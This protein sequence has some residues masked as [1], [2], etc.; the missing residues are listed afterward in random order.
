MQATEAHSNW[1]L[2]L[3]VGFHL[4]VLMRIYFFGFDGIHPLHD[5]AT[6]SIEP[7]ATRL[8]A[9]PIPR[10]PGRHA[11]SSGATSSP[12]QGATMPQ[13][14]PASSR[15]NVRRQDWSCGF[16]PT[17]PRRQRPT[18]ARPT[19]EYR[20]M[21]RAARIDPSEGC[22]ICRVIALLR[23]NKAGAKWAAAVGPAPMSHQ[24]NCMPGSARR[25]HLRAG[26]RVSQARP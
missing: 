19:E 20:R 12:L 10:P 24:S 3:T 1:I 2:Q 23:V 7:L 9:L 18:R 8:G 14:W 15:P 16:Y 4:Q 17:Q 5:S 11:G 21:D 25:M 6:H 26:T 22:R 13:G